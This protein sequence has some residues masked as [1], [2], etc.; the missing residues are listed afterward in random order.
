[1]ELKFNGLPELLKAFPDDSSARHYLEAQRWQGCPVCPFCG[2][3]KFYKLNDGKTYKCGVTGCM[4]K[5]TVTVG[6]VFH[7]SHIPLNIWFTAMYI[8]SSHKKGISSHQLAK[9]LNVTQKSAWFM[10]HRIRDMVRSKET[11]KLSGI[12]EVDETYMGRKF[13]ADMKDLTPEEIQYRLYNKQTTHSKGAIFG[14]IARNGEIVVKAYSGIKGDE[15]KADIKKHI[16]K[17]SW[18][19]TDGSFLYR[20]GLEGYKRESVIH[21]RRQYVK[22]DIHTNNVEN[23]WG[24][25]KRGIYGIYH[26]ISF[27][28]L[29]RYCDE[30]AFRHNN[31]KI[32]DNIRFELSLAKPEG[33][34]TYRQLISNVKPKEEPYQEKESEWE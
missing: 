26:Q 5:Y 4:K 8:M 9:D 30:F 31:R 12:V 20:E 11:K 33:R 18:L 10:L 27:K 24:I 34:L 15:I 3:T 23:F 2:S 28:H 22:G 6:T 21:S 17:H 13:R 7:G 25:M 14:M 19:L 1:M 16:T 29:Q 32:G